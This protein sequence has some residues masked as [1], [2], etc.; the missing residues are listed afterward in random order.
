MPELFVEILCEE[1]PARMQRKASDDFRR[2]VTNHL[3]DG[4]LN[5]EGAY[6]SATPRRLIL[7]VQGLAGRSADRT[8]ERKGPRVGA[9]DKAL[10]GFLRASGLS[11][12][13]EAQVVSDPKK[14]DFYVARIHTE[15]RPAIEICAEAVADAIKNFPWPV[16]MRWGAASAQEG[17][18]RW[19]RPL[20]SVLATFGPDNEEPEV[21][22]IAL[23]GVPVGDKTVGHRF[24]APQ[25]I[26]VRRLAD[27]QP[28]LAEAFVVVDQDRRREQIHD[29]AKNAVFA[30]GLELVEDRR[31][32]EE[33]CGLV[34][35]PVV[36]IGR[37]DEATL[38]LPEEVIRLTIREN[39]KCFVTR[40]RETGKLANAFVLTA[41]LEARDGGAEIIAGNERVVRARLADA[42]FFYE[43]DLK[44]PLEQR[45]DDLK[46][47]I[48]H[49]KLGSQF[50]RAERLASLAGVLAA[51]LSVDPASAER[52]G[53]LCKADLP[54][55][56]VGEF[57]E[58]QGYMGRRY[59]LAQGEPEAVATAIEAHYSPL[60][61]SDDVP[62]EPVAIAV[63]LADKLG[64]LTWLWAAGEKPTGS[65]DPYGLRRAAL[66]IIRIILENS[67]SLPLRRSDGS[68]LIHD[69]WGRH[70]GSAPFEDLV[71]GAGEG[72][73]R[74][75]GEQV[76]FIVERF[77]VQQ[78]DAGV[79]PE[80][81]RAIVDGLDEIDLLDIKNRIDALQTF[82][83]SDDGARLMAGYRRATN[84]LRIE[85][86]KDG[87]Y[88]PFQPTG[89]H[90]NEPEDS[91]L[92]SA[93]AKARST[94]DVRLAKGDYTG[95]ME[96]L[97]AL[98][99]PVDRYFEA[100][101]VNDDDPNVRRE[102][103]LD[104]ASLRGVTELIADFSQIPG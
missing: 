6:G 68:G 65:G 78:R 97:A 90:A 35:W 103:L 41:N 67:L 79:P 1:I 24:H 51:K 4:G 56:M 39:Q 36:L 57:P 83:A 9:P 58:L 89:D 76:R 82:L 54:T 77:I 46:N 101:L 66:G 74:D 93:I 80:I 38:A 32:L 34:E 59:A 100:V 86:K 3:V 50:D 63:A 27:Y 12:I 15:G 26:R 81:V 42:R 70:A 91:S 94:V 7:S 64:T 30:L 14:G 28:A 104:L 71:D 55:L 25:A 33:V 11:S 84:I 88:P 49:Q 23:E 53:R 17:S 18:L 13:E 43:Q 98:R 92:H 37:F 16:S 8:E 52:A 2:L 45:L 73:A 87:P 22:P 5:Y 96:G 31:L 21:V 72:A 48:F 44:V 102:R 29:G 75:G 85:E 10:A 19:V 47:V 99:E 62:R 40:E 95:A 69:A 20:T 60:G 61:P